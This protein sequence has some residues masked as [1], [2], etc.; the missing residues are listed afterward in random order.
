MIINIGKQFWMKNNLNSLVFN[1]G[2]LLNN[3]Q[4]RNEWEL[5]LIT[6]TPSYYISDEYDGEVLYN[7]Y[8]VI[9]S[10][11]LLPENYKI[12]NFEDINELIN[13]LGGKKIAGLKLKSTKEIDF[14]RIAYLNEEQQL[15]KYKYGNHFGFSAKAVGKIRKDGI[16]SSGF[17]TNYWVLNEDH[18]PFVLELIEGVDAAIIYNEPNFKKQYGNSIKD[19][20]FSLRALKK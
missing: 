8:A 19:C 16:I 3:I 11:G 6:K 4:T 18:E 2:E 12:P 17:R 13:C 10:R 1:N 9:D 5:S 7:Y 20:G 15:R 14:P